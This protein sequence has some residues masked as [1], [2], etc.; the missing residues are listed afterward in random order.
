MT[1]RGKG[2]KSHNHITDTD[3][4]VRGI[5]AGKCDYCRRKWMKEQNVSFWKY[6]LAQTAHINS[7]ACIHKEENVAANDNGGDSAGNLAGEQR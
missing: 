4:P 7:A 3:F 5:Q 1:H 2:E 6:N